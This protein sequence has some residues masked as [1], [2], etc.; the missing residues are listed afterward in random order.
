MHSK[1]IL[2]KGTKIIILLDS[3]SFNLMINRKIEKGKT[4]IKYSN[5]KDFIFYKSSVKTSYDELSKITV[6]NSEYK[7]K[8][9]IKSIYNDEDVIKYAINFFK[10]SEI[11]DSEIELMKLIFTVDDF[12]RN[13]IKNPCLLITSNKKFLNN[14]LKLELDFQ[15][16]EINIVNINEAIEIMGLYLR[17]KNLY[18]VAQNYKVNKGL[19]YDIAFRK[20][21]PNYSFDDVNLSSFA[22]R[23]MYILMSIDEMGYQYYHGVNNDIHESIMYHFNYFTV[24]LAGIFDSFALIT[25]KKCNIGFD[26]NKA[27]FAISLKNK[28]FLK[29]L[30][31]KDLKLYQHIIKFF[32]YI[33]LIS[34]L[35]NSIIHRGIFSQMI[36][37]SL[38]GWRG[39]FLKIDLKIFNLIFKIDPKRVIFEG[40]SEWGLY[41]NC[42]D[43]QCI[44]MY[45]FAKRALKEIVIFSTEYLSLLG[46]SK[47]KGKTVNSLD[48]SAEILREFGL[49]HY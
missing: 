18:Y 17:Y 6:L 33:S 28:E 48:N 19:W 31:T 39:S 11:K 2:N 3:D 24:L 10:D 45:V 14:R 15:T 44:D 37:N 35:R 46:Y 38:D 43:F 32:D 36:I 9:N 40:L 27:P 7:E 22:S 16:S 4:I 47:I 21:I 20:Y 23:F 42:R 29:K 8:N 1:K 25:N 30:E 34:E 49:Y 26:E 13:N 12:R 5:S 41:E